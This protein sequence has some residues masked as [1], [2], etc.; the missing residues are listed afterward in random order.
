MQKLQGF[1]HQPSKIVCQN[2]QHNS[3]RLPFPGT[4]L[5]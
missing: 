5:L 4:L 2:A 1:L 3:Q